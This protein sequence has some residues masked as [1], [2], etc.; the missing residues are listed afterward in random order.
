[1]DGVAPLAVDVLP[2]LL[3]FAD[4][5]FPP[6]AVPS[7]ACFD[8]PRV[9]PE[10][11]VS[12][13]SCVGSLAERF[14]PC[15]ALLACALDDAIA[16][17]ASLVVPRSALPSALD[18]AAARVVPIHGGTALA[19]DVLLLWA[20]SL[21]GK[22]TALAA[23]WGSAL[24][25][26]ELPAAVLSAFPSELLLAGRFVPRL[27]SCALGEAPKS[28]RCLAEITPSCNVFSC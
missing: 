21:L 18:E 20:S 9:L 24:P 2:A 12:T 17:G 14:V 13:F 25:I 11:V 5:T 22:A 10:A 1:M 28:A 4:N 6:E 7:F 3:R 16:V 19:H 23:S 27:L 26:A 15:F 8:F